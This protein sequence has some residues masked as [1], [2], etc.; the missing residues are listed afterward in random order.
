M[1]ADLVRSRTSGEE[2]NVGGEGLM[3]RVDR[4][5]GKKEESREEGGGGNK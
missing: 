5:S 1:E 3:K 2:G 4:I